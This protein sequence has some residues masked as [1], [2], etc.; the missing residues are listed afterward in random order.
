LLTGHKGVGIETEIVARRSSSGENEGTKSGSCEGCHKSTLGQDI[1]GGFTEKDPHAEGSS[2][3]K[4]LQ[5][6]KETDA[7]VENAICGEG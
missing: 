2:T 7:V 3:S 6:F 5:R 1:R 4:G